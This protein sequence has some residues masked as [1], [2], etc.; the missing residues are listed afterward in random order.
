MKKL[1][2]FLLALMMGLSLLGCGTAAE[3][4]ATE[5]PT[6]QVPAT[7]AIA[8]EAPTEAP[9]EPFVLDLTNS[10]VQQALA[11][12][13]TQTARFE[14]ALE[15]QEILRELGFAEVSMFYWDHGFQ[16]GDPYV[17]KDLTW[18]GDCFR[19]DLDFVATRYENGECQILD[20]AEGWV[21][22]GTKASEPRDLSGLKAEDFDY[23][24]VMNHNQMFPEFAN[25]FM[26]M[27]D[28]AYYS[29]D[30]N[31]LP[32]FY[33]QNVALYFPGTGNLYNFIKHHEEALMIEDSRPRIVVEREFDLEL[34]QR[35]DRWVNWEDWEDAR[36][37]AVT[38]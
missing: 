5:V 19:L 31:D 24:D 11:G 18:N 21:V 26:E 2:S 33:I 28:Y 16:Y 34:F 23:A 12:E 3:P 27:V 20:M 4:A 17:L 35:V 14:T 7:E 10:P 13:G 29:I 25:E 6:I 15:Y 37:F 1:F 22:Y 9:A 30:E 38:E 32:E 8:T 36:E